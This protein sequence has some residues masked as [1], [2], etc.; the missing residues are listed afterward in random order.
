MKPYLSA[1]RRNL[2]AGARLCLFRD[3][4]ADDFEVSLDQLVL[5]IA[6]NLLLAFFVDLLS[7]LP[8]PEFYSYAVA[9]NGLDIVL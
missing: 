7:S 2:N 6:L 9:A 4:A 3:C 1:L 8:R 5:L